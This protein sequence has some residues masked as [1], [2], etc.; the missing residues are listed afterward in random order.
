M[1]GSFNF[2]KRDFPVSK[3]STEGSFHRVSYKGG[4][5]APVW[6]S[7]IQGH[8]KYPYHERARVLEVNKRFFIKDIVAMHPKKETTI[9]KKVQKTVDREGYQHSSHVAGTRVPVR[10]I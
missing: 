10:I 4:N 8:R 3:F 9:P 2:L 7:L 5:A 6:I 1:H